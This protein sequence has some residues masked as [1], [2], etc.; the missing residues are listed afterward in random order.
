MN[1]DDTKESTPKRSTNPV[2]A[3]LSGAVTNRPGLLMR[4]G[5]THNNEPP[6]ESYSKAK[7][8]LYA[9]GLPLWPGDK[10][11]YVP[12]RCALGTREVEGSGSR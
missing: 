5:G 2:F 9:A 11:Y 4:E 6:D 1:I 7:A 10:S 12:C 3:L 8:E